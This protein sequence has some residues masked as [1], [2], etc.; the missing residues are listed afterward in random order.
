MAIAFAIFGVSYA[1]FCI[2]LTVRIANRRERWAKRAA[3]AA[4]FVPLLYALSSGPLKTAVVFGYRNTFRSMMRPDGT[5][6]I[7]ATSVY[8]PAEW[9]PTLYAP[10]SWVSE[11]LGAESVV[12]WYLGLFPN[13]D[14]PEDP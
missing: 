12:D 5:V 7:E 9:Y 6:G 8:G 4:A 3:V 10:L 2:W 1:A 13:R 11:K 14:A